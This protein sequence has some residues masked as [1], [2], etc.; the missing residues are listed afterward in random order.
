MLSSC[1]TMLDIV[2]I[3]VFF[4]RKFVF[5]EFIVNQL[6]SS[7]GSTKNVESLFVIEE[8]YEFGNFIACR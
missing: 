6:D 8:N 2:A 4:E 7:L 1:Y 5:K 3:I